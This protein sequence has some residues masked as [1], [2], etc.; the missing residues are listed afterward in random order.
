MKCQCGNEL[1]H[2]CDLSIAERAKVL[3]K[4]NQKYLGPAFVAFEAAMHVY[5]VI[6]R[7]V[8]GAN[9]PVI[10]FTAFELTMFIYLLFDNRRAK[11]E[12]GRS[13]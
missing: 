6:Y 11:G 1:S 2:Y 9:I 3:W 10:G 7:I 4:R 12:D 13:L 8:I 5:L